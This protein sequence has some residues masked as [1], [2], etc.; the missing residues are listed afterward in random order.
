MSIFEKFNKKVNLKDL[1]EGLREIQENGG[2]EVREDVP[3]GTYEVA[4]EKMEIKECKSE[5][6]KGDALFTC[7]FK[8]VA[9]DY[10]DSYIFMNQLI[11]QPFQIHIVNEFL[12]SLDSDIE[13][14]FD[15]Y[16]QYNDLI[17]DIH[18]AIKGK[19]E[20][21]LD[22]SQTKKGYNQFEI[23]EVFDV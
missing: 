16:V 20:Y 23:T 21:C 12:R 8:I 22:Y 14:T 3:Y 4:I 9:G 1:Q 10:K 2:A 13:V 7:W 18:E 5:A 6:H 19:L 11:A 15:D 17:L